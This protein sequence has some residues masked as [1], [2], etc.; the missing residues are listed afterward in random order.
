MHDA[1]ISGAS[2]NAQSLNILSECTGFITIGKMDAGLAG[3]F[4]SSVYK[5]GIRTLC[6]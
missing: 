3:V 4:F 5:N 2:M 1:K 6:G